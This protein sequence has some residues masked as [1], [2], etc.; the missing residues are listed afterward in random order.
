MKSIL[1]WIAAGSLFASLAIAQ[2]HYTVTDLG[3]LGG[4]GTNSNAFGL[5]GVGWA[6]GSSS[7]V[8]NGPQLAFIWYGYGPAIELGTLGGHECTTCNSEANGLNLFGETA[9]GSETPNMDPNGE[10]FCAYGTHHQCLGAIGRRWTLTALP[11][12]PGGN[13]ANAF[14][15]NDLGQVVGTS[16]NGISD[17]TCVSATPFQVLRFVPVRWGLGGRIQ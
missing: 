3:T 2:P 9:I 5:N 13:N 10:D 6:A 4:P 1:T 12:L 16:E 17:P 11:L 8:A 15:V 7:L 14:D